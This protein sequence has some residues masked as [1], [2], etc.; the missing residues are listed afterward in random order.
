MCPDIKFTSA[1]EPVQIIHTEGRLERATT[2]I[3][4]HQINLA[5]GHTQCYQRVERTSGPT[6]FDVVLP[7]RISKIN[8]HCQLYVTIYL[9]GNKLDDRRLSH[10]NAKHVAMD[11]Q[12]MGSAIK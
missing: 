7:D 9:F 12:M 4:S 10:S 8:K 6:R 2:S 5:T 3:V 11:E 1:C